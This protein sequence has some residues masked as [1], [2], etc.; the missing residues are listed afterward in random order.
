MFN[1]NQIS[2]WSSKL[3]NG[4]R[5]ALSKAITL[6][7][8]S[9]AEDKIARKSILK[10]LKSES[11]NS[12]RIGITGPPGAGKST[13][14][15]VLGL[16]LI[17]QGFSVAVLSIDPSSAIT[18]GSILGDKTRMQR[19]ALEAKS[20]I[21]PSPAGEHLGG[22][23]QRTRESI[24]LCEAAGFDFVLVETAGIGQSEYQVST[25]TDLTILL[26]I[27]GAGDDLQGIKKGILEW[28]DIIVLNK[29]DHELDPISI[30]SYNDLLVANHFIQSNTPGWNRK[31]IRT[32][33]LNNL[34]I[35]LL[36]DEI[37]AFKAFI[38]REKYIIKHRLDQLKNYYRDLLK[39]RIWQQAM[40][41]PEVLKYL[42]ETEKNIIDLQISPEEAADISLAFI[43]AFFNKT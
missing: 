21:R 30:R 23:A 4:D 12:L 20:F 34:G 15:E 22:V 31:I 39:G 33:A 29:V 10:D 28:T 42:E 9:K 25:M 8:S 37:F 14:I 13:L 43:F 18:K 1:L 24:W 36:M 32:S 40:Q 38:I 26:N 5:I 16:A 3:K 6:I 7:E 35:D 2:E 19:L 41:S 27:P 11:S 17:N